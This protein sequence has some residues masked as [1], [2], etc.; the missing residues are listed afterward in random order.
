VAGSIAITI[1]ITPWL[2][3]WALVCTF[4]FALANIH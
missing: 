1:I 4:A 3:H 2:L